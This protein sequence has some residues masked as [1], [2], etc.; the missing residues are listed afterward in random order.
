MST[1]P[2]QPITLYRHP[3]SGHSHRAQLLLSLAGMPARLV[4]VDLMKGA[5]KQPDFLKLNAFGQVPVIDDD[6]TV[7]AD[8]NAILVYLATPLRQSLVVAARCR[9]RRRRPALAVGRRR[10]DRLRPGR[11][12]ADHGVRREVRRR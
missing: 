9:G 4:D 7:V 8:A 6:G 10:A 5:H 1:Q 12:A 11:G 3:L 2:T